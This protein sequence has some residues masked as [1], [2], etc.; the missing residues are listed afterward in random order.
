M[1]GDRL[2]HLGRCVQHSLDR[3][4][5]TVT[6]LIYGLAAFFMV[7]LCCMPYSIFL[8]VRYCYKRREQRRNAANGGG[9]NGPAGFQEEVPAKG[10]KLLSIV[11]L[12][13][14]FPL[15][16]YLEAR[17]IKETRLSE[18]AFEQGPALEAQ[19]MET[20]TVIQEKRLSDSTLKE[21]LPP[22]PADVDNE[23]VYGTG[24]ATTG[25]AE[26]RFVQYEPEDAIERIEVVH[27]N[28]PNVP[29]K[30]SVEIARKMVTEQPHAVTISPL[31]KN[32]NEIKITTSNGSTSGGADASG[33]NNDRVIKTDE[34]C[35]ICIEP[36]EDADKVRLLTCGHM[37]HS[38][39][40]D[41]WLTTR[42]AYCP[43]CKLEFS[44]NG[45][46]AGTTGDG[47]A[48]QQ[49]DMQML[50]QAIAASSPQ[51]PAPVTIQ[52]NEGRVRRHWWRR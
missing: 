10:R 13:S 42:R 31:D 2:E 16:T 24:A 46:G 7:V 30:S 33:T 27:D 18:K 49:D 23:K 19:T 44:G 29:R 35:A 25:A 8:I 50:L 5:G 43:L 28:K 14:L 21:H 22:I 34:M 47:S 48:P 52:E 45:T 36:M 51:E 41:P 6:D 3:V 1:L 40:V 9:V 38:E 17:K 15:M 12:E 39:C 20:T 32:L 26:T 37:F 4:I 11:E